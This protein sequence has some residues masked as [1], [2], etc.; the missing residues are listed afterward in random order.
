M[1]FTSHDHERFS[2]RQYRIVN[3]K[4]TTHV[5]LPEFFLI[6]FT[7][8]PFTLWDGIYIIPIHI[9]FSEIASRNAQS[10]KGLNCCRDAL[11]HITAKIRPFPLWASVPAISIH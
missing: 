4:D 1:S 3:P 7:V 10:W 5:E 9:W 11:K 8:G 2:I 6:C